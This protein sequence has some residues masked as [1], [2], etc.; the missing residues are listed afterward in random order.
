MD[1]SSEFPPT[2]VIRLSDAAIRHDYSRGTVVAEIG[3]VGGNARHVIIA[4]SSEN[5][6]QLIVDLFDHFEVVESSD[7]VVA[8]KRRAVT[9][10]K[11]IEISDR[12][13]L[14]RLLCILWLPN[15][16]SQSAQYKPSEQERS[17][18]ANLPAGTEHIEIRLA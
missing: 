4:S 1:N 18:L 11:Q 7:E 6:E 3:P 17:A 5:R 13:W 9:R 15:Y 10:S 16:S 14:N 12:S 8:L 2:Y